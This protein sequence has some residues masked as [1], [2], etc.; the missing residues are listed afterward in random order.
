MPFTTACYG[1][2]HT[3]TICTISSETCLTFT[4][5][6]ASCISTSGILVTIMSFFTAFINICNGDLKLAEKT[7]K[8]IEDGEAFPRKSTT[9]T[10]LSPKR[11]LQNFY[12][13]KLLKCH[14]K[15]L[16]ANK[17]T[18][19]TIVYNISELFMYRTTQSS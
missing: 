16:T 15:L 8:N 19:T 10:S 5:K 11:I 2:C 7:E 14:S 12:L 4:D 17:Q 13:V 9:I 3:L 18:A 1:I 6:R